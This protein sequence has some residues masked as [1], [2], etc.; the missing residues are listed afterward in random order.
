MGNLSMYG[1]VV[2]CVM[3]FSLYYERHFGVFEGIMAELA[4][5]QALFGRDCLVFLNILFDWWNLFSAGESDIDQL[6]R[7]QKCLGPLPM[8]YMDAMKINPKFEG[9]KVKCNIR[10]YG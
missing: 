4:T 1:R 6:Y 10:I 5:G 3:N 2:V 8:K 9:L 7:I